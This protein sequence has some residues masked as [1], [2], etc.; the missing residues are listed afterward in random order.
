MELLKEKL[1]NKKFLPAT[2][3]STW[4]GEM[5]QEMSAYF[6]KNCHWLMRIYPRQKLYD[7]FK[8]IR[9]MGKRDFNYFI[10]MLKK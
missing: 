8:A 3:N 2:K 7:K 10:G 1:K 9:D 4:Y 5:G 6:G